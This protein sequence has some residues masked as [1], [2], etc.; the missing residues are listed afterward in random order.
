LKKLK[1][2]LKLSTLLYKLGIDK[3]RAI[4]RDVLDQL[5]GQFKYVICGAAPVSRDTLYFFRAIG[6]E[7]LAGYG[8]TEASPVVGGG[9]TKVNRYGTT[10]EPLAG[11]E[12]AIDDDGSGTGEILVRSDIVMKGYLDDPEATAEAIDEDGWLHTADVGRW[13][14]HGSLIITAGANR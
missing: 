12:V 8:L 6:V 13:T 5:G 10:G 4:F 1:F 7:V 2:G 9:N 11:V 14:R 3:R